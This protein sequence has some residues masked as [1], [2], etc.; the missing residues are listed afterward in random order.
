M[1]PD[2]Y[3]ALFVIDLQDYNKKLIF[4]KRFSA[5]YFWKLQLHHFSKIKIP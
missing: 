4:E 3:P 5:S 2:P 1:D